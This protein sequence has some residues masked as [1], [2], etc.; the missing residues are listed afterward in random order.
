MECCQQNVLSRF[1]VT[2]LLALHLEGRRRGA[3][4]LS[5]G[6]FCRARFIVVASRVS[7][8]CVVRGR[9]ALC[10]SC[11]RCPLCSLL[12]TALTPLPTAAFSRSSSSPFSLL[13]LPPTMGCGSSNASA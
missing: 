5:N 11:D 6:C 7:V 12:C 1:A 8:A 9:V 2:V 10:P 13:S 3:K 4:R